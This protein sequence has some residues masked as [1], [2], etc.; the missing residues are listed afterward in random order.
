VVSNSAQEFKRGA[1]TAIASGYV[2][3]VVG[4]ESFLQTTRVDNQ[5]ITIKRM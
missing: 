4:G 5:R 3:G 1:A 2:E